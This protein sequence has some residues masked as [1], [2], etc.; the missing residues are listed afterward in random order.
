MGELSKKLEKLKK[1]SGADRIDSTRAEYGHD[2][3]GQMQAEVGT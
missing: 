3:L 2:A 1:T